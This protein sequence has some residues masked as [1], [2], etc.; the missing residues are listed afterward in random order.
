MYQNYVDICLHNYLLTE[1]DTTEMS[2][3]KRVVS[4]P[5]EFRG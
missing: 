3:I 2:I 1:A 5:T 4:A